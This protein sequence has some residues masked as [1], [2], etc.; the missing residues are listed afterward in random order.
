MGGQL[1]SPK[2]GLKGRHKIAICLTAVRR[3]GVNSTA[4]LHTLQVNAV[5]GSGTARNYF[6]GTGAVM[7]TSMYV[8]LYS[9]YPVLIFWRNKVREEIATILID[10]KW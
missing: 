5:C 1:L 6:S 10:V 9:L 2:T 8:E 4:R 3:R 7:A